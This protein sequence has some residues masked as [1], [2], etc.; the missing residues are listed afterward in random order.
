M[1]NPY[2]HD[3]S[4]QQ[5]HPAYNCGYLET[6]YTANRPPPSAAH[7]PTQSDLSVSRWTSSQG[8]DGHSYGFMRDFP[9]SSPGGG[10]FGELRLAF[11]Y[12]YDPL[13]PSPYACPPSGHFS[14]M[15]PPA[16]VN[17]YSSRGAS[18]FQTFNQQFRS[19]P[20]TAQ[21]EPDSIQKQHRHEYQDFSVSGSP[22]GFPL[23]PQ[24]GED[25]DQSPG[26]TARA[27]DDTAIQTKQDQQWLRRFLQSRDKTPKISQTQNSHSCVPELRRALY[28][29]AQLVSQLAKSCDTLRSNANNDCVWTNFYLTALNGKREL[30]DK[31]RILD[32]W[33]LD[34]WKSKLSRVAKRRVR[35]LRA[36]ELQQMDEK[37]R[38]ERIS[39]KEAAIDK[40]RLRQIRQVEDKKK[41]NMHP[42]MFSQFRSPSDT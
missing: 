10:S 35:R 29:A 9:A 8:Y 27:E 28:R 36:M 33:G 4:D 31:F 24:R 7:E 1:D 38:E 32:S 12:G 23:Y 15:V 22:F 16:P 17:T 13:A 39:E 37:Q 42:S 3:P 21:Y 20:P 18:A 6:P 5:Q 26:T 14:N 11:P 19:G 34:G 30:Q 2:R 25:H 41:V 40:W